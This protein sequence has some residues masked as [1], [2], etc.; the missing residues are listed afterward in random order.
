MINLETGMFD[1]F[2]FY[3]KNGNVRNDISGSAEPKNAKDLLIYYF[4]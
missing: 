1:I 3:D 2:K 4:E